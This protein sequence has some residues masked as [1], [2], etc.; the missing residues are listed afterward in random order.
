MS[1]CYD[2]SIALFQIHNLKMNTFDMYLISLKNHPSQTVMLLL[3]LEK[4][5][6]FKLNKL[7]VCFTFTNRNYRMKF[8]QLVRN[9]IDVGPSKTAFYF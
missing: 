1:N 6:I 8:V 9:K 7:N 5:H 2:V 4:E 3:Y